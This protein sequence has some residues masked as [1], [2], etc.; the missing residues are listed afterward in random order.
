MTHQT[1]HRK[2]GIRAALLPILTIAFLSVLAL[3]VGATVHLMRQEKPVAPVVPVEQPTTVIGDGQTTTTP[4]VTA[5]TTKKSTTVKS[6]VKTTVTTTTAKATST[7]EPD[8]GTE[9][10]AALTFD[11][12]PGPY[13]EQLLDYLKSQ[14]VPATFFLIGRNVSEKYEPLLR[15]MIDE[16]HDV[17]GH[18]YSHKKLTQLAA[19]DLTREMNKSTAA[20]KT[21]T[22]LPVTL[23]RAPYGAVNSAVQARARE[24]GLRLIGWSVDTN[25]WR[26]QKADQAEAQKQILYNTFDGKYPVKN[27]AIILMH[28]VHKNSV[29]SVPALVEE[30]QARGY[31]LVTVSDLLAAR[32]DGGTP[33]EVYKRVKP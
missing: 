2:R 21:V 3:G 31:R 26:Y 29:D 20:V 10:L 28:D 30:L 27:G 16:G 24:M 4:P 19:S 7:T 17:G 33:G 1:N 18:S 32:A 8:D 6:T 15:R 14:N 22:G 23:F 25:D 13:T 5:A 9:K 12:G 11:D